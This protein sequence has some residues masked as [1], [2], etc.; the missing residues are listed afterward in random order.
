M[1]TWSDIADRYRQSPIGKKLYKEVEKRAKVPLIFNNYSISLNQMVWV[2]ISSVGSWTLCRE[3][4]WWSSGSLQVGVCFWVLYSKW[5]IY[6]FKES[7]EC[8]GEVFN[9]RRWRLDI[10]LLWLR[11]LKRSIILN[12]LKSKLIVSKNSQITL[13]PNFDKNLKKISRNPSFHSI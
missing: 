2:T 13:I 9:R 4:L 7:C 8:L 6:Y 10:A 11:K 3:S 1:P 5:T 12:L